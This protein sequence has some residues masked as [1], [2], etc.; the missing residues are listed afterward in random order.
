MC[1]LKAILVT[2]VFVSFGVKH[3]EGASSKGDLASNV[4][5]KC[6]EW[7]ARLHLFIISF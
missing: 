3:K 2:T 4:T 7:C 6:G 5:G 1:L